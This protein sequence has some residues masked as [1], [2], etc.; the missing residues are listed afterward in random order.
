[1]EKIIV[2]EMGIS[3]DVHGSCGNYLN[4][5]VGLSRLRDKEPFGGFHRPDK[6]QIRNGH[7]IETRFHTGYGE[8]RNDA[9]AG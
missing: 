6:Q 7:G 5:N 8:L 9:V 3:G 2:Q 1:M 4:L